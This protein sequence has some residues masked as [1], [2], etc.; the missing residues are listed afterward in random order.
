MATVVSR[1]TGSVN[2]V[3]NQATAKVPAVVVMR[4]EERSG[5]VSAGN[6]WVMQCGHGTCGMPLDVLRKLGVTSSRLIEIAYL[7]E[8]GS[9]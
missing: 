7:T 3:I 2:F 8:Y 4:R 9:H 1:R 5:S 6:C